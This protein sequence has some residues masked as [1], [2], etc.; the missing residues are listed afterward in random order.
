MHIEPRNK[1]REL[2]NMIYYSANSLLQHT[3]SSCSQITFKVWMK[4]VTW[5]SRDNLIIASFTLCTASV[6]SRHGN[7]APRICAP[8]AYRLLLGPGWLSG[9]SPWSRGWTARVLGAVCTGCRLYWVP[10]ALC[11]VC[12]GCRLR[13]CKA[14]GAWALWTALIG[15]WVA[16]RWELLVNVGTE[17]GASSLSWKQFRCTC[18]NSSATGMHCLLLL[19]ACT[20]WCVG[21]GARYPT[22]SSI[23]T[24][25]G[26]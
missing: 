16:E 15:C 8:P 6:F 7:L 12:T 11:A 22:G 3:A 23:P 13:A 4:H 5:L 21:R 18:K 9:H 2:K 1:T 10:F 26:C 19:S 20:N 25:A 14:D 24:S 17:S